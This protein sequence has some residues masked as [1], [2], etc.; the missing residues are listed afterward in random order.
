M[1]DLLGIKSLILLSRIFQKH[2]DVKGSPFAA[3]QT[4]FWYVHQECMQGYQQVATRR[5]RTGTGL[6]ADWTDSITRHNIL[7]WLLNKSLWKIARMHPIFTR[8]KNM[9]LDLQE[10]KSLCAWL[11]YKIFPNRYMWNKPTGGL[12]ESH[13]QRTHL[14]NKLANL[15]SATFLKT[16][17][18]SN[19]E[20]W[21]FF[22]QV[23]VM[24]N[25]DSNTISYMVS[26]RGISAALQNQTTWRANRRKRLSG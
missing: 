1:S 2:F 26:L 3:M 18:S 16:E 11:H 23:N 10:F 21:L 12:Q 24:N 22:C 8:S 4:H 20:S 25:V 15:F 13:F 19:W 7:D 17:W 14:P 9:Q 6:V 5:P